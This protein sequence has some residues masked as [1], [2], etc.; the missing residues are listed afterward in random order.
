MP[1]REAKLENDLQTLHLAYALEPVQHGKI[2]ARPQR[3][4]V[5]HNIGCRRVLQTR[6]EGLPNEP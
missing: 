6:D 3:H 4:A 2:R 5:D 1:A